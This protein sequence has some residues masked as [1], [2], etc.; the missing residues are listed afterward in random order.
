MLIEKKRL[1]FIIVGLFLNF[2]VKA[3]VDTVDFEAMFEQMDELTYSNPDS[4]ISIGQKAYKLAVNKS[5]DKN[6]AYSLYYLGGIFDI[7]GLYEEA[8]SYYFDALKIFEKINDKKGIGGCLNCIGIVLWEQSELSSDKVKKQ[9]LLK[10]LEYINKALEYYTE[11]GYIK[12]RAVCYMNRGIVLDDYYQLLDNLTEQNN[13]I[14]MSMDSYSE[15]IKSFDLINDIRSKADC[16]LNL[17]SLYYDYFVNDFDS[18]FTE[19]E[20]VNVEKYYTD[21]LSLYEQSNDLYGIAMTLEN[22]A[23]IKLEH[24][25][26]EHMKTQYIDLAIKDALKAVSYAD[27]V[28]S[29][30]IKYDAYLVLYKAYK[31]KNQLDKALLYHELYIETKDIV[32]QTEQLD[33]I[34]EMETRYNVE[35]KEQQIKLQDIEIQQTRYKNTVQKYVIIATIGFILIIFVFLVVLYRLSHQRRKINKILTEKNDELSNLN[36]TQNRLMSIISHDLKSPLSAF[37]SITSSLKTKFDK[38]ERQ[39]ID[40]Y[41]DRMLNSSVA[42]KLQL[43]NMLNWSINQ[44]KKIS[45][46]KS[47]YKLNIVVYKVVMILQEFA[48]EK[49]IIIENNVTEDIE[50]ETDSR[51]L[52]IVLNNLISNAVKFS[53]DNGKVVVCAEKNTNKTRIFITDFGI[54][55]TREETVNLFNKN[56][57]VA[58]NENTGTG[59]GLIVSKDLVEKL[60]GKI[61]VS[62]EPGKGT[63]FKIEL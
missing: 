28:N 42:L 2:V 45:V 47:I 24:A 59:L 9:K 18:V 7:Q 39:E 13:Y 54:G 48:N 3:Q 6:I 52:S 63:E 19:T 43:E 22:L 11:I 21:A 23:A 58:K 20:F 32:H 50:L 4:A 31:N 1:L 56:L 62:S 25:E 51:L 35:K 8:Y 29:L 16:Y 57:N 15:A 26:S 41:F 14:L 49:S 46:H 38:L 60:G 44:T 34:E 17:A 10:S 30:F 12:G 36:A 27:S 55:M 40:N 53:P 5:D 33:A 37:Y 61:S